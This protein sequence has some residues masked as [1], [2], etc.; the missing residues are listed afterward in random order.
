VNALDLFSGI[1]GF[2]LGFERAGIDTL[3]FCESDDAC[4][5]HLANR[6][7]HVP[8]FGD[9]RSLAVEPGFC[10]V[11]CGGF[12]CQPFSTASRGRKV[13]TDLWPEFRRIVRM[14]RPVWVVAENVPGIAD[15]GIERVCGDLED[16]DYSVWPFDTDT[17]LPA[18]Q[19]GRHRI[20]W[21]AHSNDALHD[22][23]AFDAEMAGVCEV[24]RSRW[25]NDPAP[26]GVD[27][28]LHGRMDRFR[29]LGNALTPYF[30]EIIGRAIVRASA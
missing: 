9:V 4:I 5:A 19:R 2:A 25:E 30:A 20:I 6:W 24:S 11:L 21:L 22:R 17:A 12:P 15:E 27:D 3:A 1:G 16:A 7:P 10:D 29:Q 13:A 14:A 28:V 23:F 26:V 18:R 8:V